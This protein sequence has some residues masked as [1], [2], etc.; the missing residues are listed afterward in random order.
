MK[1]RVK[2]KFYDVDF[3]LIDDDDNILAFYYYTNLRIKRTLNNDIFLNSD[4]KIDIELI[5]DLLSK[6]NMSAEEVEKNGNVII[7]NIMYHDVVP[8]TQNDVNRIK[9]QEVINSIDY[10]FVL[11]DNNQHTFNLIKY[12]NHKRVKKQVAN[13]MSS[14]SS[15]AFA[16]MMLHKHNLRC[17]LVNTFDN[18]IRYYEIISFAECKKRDKELEELKKNTDKQVTSD[19]DLSDLD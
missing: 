1:V 6:Y 18:N 14:A 19:F 2:N 8:L 16:N 15:I 10:D 11:R 7:Y 13:I 9:K 4:I 17:Y 5:N 12:N 3:I